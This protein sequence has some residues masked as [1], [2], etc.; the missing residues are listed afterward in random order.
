VEGYGTG[1]RKMIRAC[2]ENGSF[3]PRFEIDHQHFKVTFPRGKKVPDEILE[4]DENAVMELI[5]SD[6][7]T[8]AEETHHAFREQAQ[9]LLA[10]ESRDLLRTS[11]MN[12]IL[13]SYRGCMPA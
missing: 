4:E 11:Q 8:S 10:S 7:G 5:K 6:A 1:I 9:R 3:E 12:L 13:C 2:E